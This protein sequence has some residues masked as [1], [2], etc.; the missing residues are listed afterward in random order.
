[1]FARLSA[2]LLLA[3]G[4]APEAASPSVAMIGQAPLP[5]SMN[6]TVSPLIPGSQATFQITGAAPNAELLVLRSVGGQVGQGACPP[7]LGGYCLDITGRPTLFPYY[8][9][10][11]ALGQVAFSI[12]LPG[13]VSLGTEVAFQALDLDTLQGSNPVLSVVG[14]GT[15]VGCTDDSFEDND[16][17]ATA[18]NG[19]TSSSSLRVCANDDDYYAYTVPAGGSIQASFSFDHGGDGDL[20]VTLLSSSGAELDSSVS[21]TDSELVSWT[22]TTSAA[23]E[24]YVLATMYS[25]VGTDGID[26]AMSVS[27]TGGSNNGGSNNG[28][29]NN[30][31]SNAVFEDDCGQG[32]NDS[33]ADATELD[34]ANDTIADVQLCSGE[35][36]W[37]TVD[38]PPGTW[39]SLEVQIQGSGAGGTD[40]DLYETDA[41]GASY[42]SSVSEQ[43]YERLAVYND[44]NTTRAFTFVVDGYNSASADYDL[45]VATSPWHEVR[46]CDDV[47]TSWS[48]SDETGPCNRIMQFPRSYAGSDGVLVTHESHYNNLRREVAYLVTYAARQTAA[49]YPSAQ[50][51]ALLDMG[52]ANGDTP[53]AMVNSLRHPEGTHVEG[54]DIDIAYYQTGPD[55]LGR[56]VCPNDGYF[57]TGTPNLLDAEVSAYFMAQLFTSPNVRVVGVDTEIAD[58]LIASADDLYQAGMISAGQR[59]A[60]TSQMAYGQGWPFHHHHLHLSWNWESGW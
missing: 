43:S 16:T 29:S 39:M 50:P 57:C 19:P 56:A 54:N 49:A 14:G 47:Y 36:D 9:Q 35:Q 37:Y 5:Q 30:G 20:D 34:A 15:A 24:V 22:N 27:V 33:P 1:M 40:L 17:R 18:A 41:S 48:P 51:I 21:T 45:V 38:V 46:D 55:N 52:E 28:G 25:D 58:L 2:L 44:T 60:F 42:Q 26:Y 8:Y 53:G 7:V 32:L 4:C 31:G 6:L 13:R 59:N 11:D 12:T 10:A 3:A 23:R